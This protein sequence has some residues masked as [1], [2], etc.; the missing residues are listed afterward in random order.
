MNIPQ[1][2]QAFEAYVGAFGSNHGSMKYVFKL[3]RQFILYSFPNK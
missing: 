1:Y 2:I 3:L